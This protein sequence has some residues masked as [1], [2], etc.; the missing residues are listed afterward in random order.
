MVGWPRNFKNKKMKTRTDV[1][2]HLIKRHSLKSYCELGTQ[3]REINFDKI[4]CQDKFCVDIDPNAKAD[5]TGSTD[6]F[7][8]QLKRTYDLYFI[9]ASH[10][11]EQVRKD[12]I[13]AQNALNDGGFIVLHD[14]S[15]E[16]EERTLIPRPTKTGTW[17]GDVW[18]VAVAFKGF[19]DIGRC[20]VN[21]DHGCMVCIVDINKKIT[22]GVSQI[23]WDYFNANR[24]EL[25][26]LISWQEF[27]EL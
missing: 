23:P 17:N 7:F 15:P 2:N 27:I 8:S 25:L 21:V 11:S 9:D 20:T 3:V 19:E 26:N 4:E 10:E 14:V 5:F 13:G 18:R 16:T 6:D 24:K 22:P 1:L 12:F